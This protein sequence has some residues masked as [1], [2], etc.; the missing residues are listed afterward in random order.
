MID[1]TEVVT[2]GS[3]AVYGSD[4]ITGVINFIMKDDFEGVQVGGQYGFDSSTSTPTKNFDLTFGGNFAEGRGNAVVS[5]NYYK[6]EGFTRA[7]RG[8]WAELPYGE[9][10]VTAGI[11]QRQ[12]DRRRQR[13]VGGQLR[14]VGRHAWA[15]SSP[16]AA[17]SPMAASC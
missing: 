14:G 9:A 12:P 1:R 2:G 15:S 5:L 7:E 16:A 6:R 17:T 3:S 8:D 10:C 11:L 4:A 13:F